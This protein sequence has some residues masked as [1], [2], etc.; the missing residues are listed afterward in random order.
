VEDIE[1]PLLAKRETHPA[2]T[3]ELLNTL[4]TWINEG[5]NAVRRLDFGRG[6]SGQSEIQQNDHVI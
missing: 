1:I 3:L 6:M 2:P 5:A 4:I